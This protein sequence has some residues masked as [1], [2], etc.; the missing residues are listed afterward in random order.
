VKVEFLEGGGKL[1]GGVLILRSRKTKLQWGEGKRVRYIR[2]GEERSEKGKRGKLFVTGK[3][4]GR[5]GPEQPR[6]GRKLQ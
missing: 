3:R 1:S 5:R 6:E 2:A 4:K